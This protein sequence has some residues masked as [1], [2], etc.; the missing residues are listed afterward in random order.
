[1]SVL[2]RALDFR[3]L[4]DESP[5]VIALRSNSL[6]LMLAVFGEYFSAAGARQYVSDLHA[7]IDSDLEALDEY[8]VDHGSRNA[9]ELCRAWINM[10]VLARRQDP[11]TGYEYYELTAIGQTV[12]GFISSLLKPRAAATQSRLAMVTDQIAGLE[13]ATNPDQQKR[14]QA[15]LKQREDLDKQIQRV[16]EGYIEVMETDR[17]R[18]SISDLAELAAQVP[19][20]FARVRESFDE[21]SHELRRNLLDSET[22]QEDILTEVFMNLDHISQSDEGKS[23]NAFYSL[24]LDERSQVTFEEAIRGLDERGM[25]SHLPQIERQMLRTYMMTLQNEALPVSNMMRTLSRN[26]RQFVQSRQFQEYRAIN[27][28]LHE[29]Q[30]LGLDA[31]SLI[32]ATEQIPIE[33]PTTSFRS[34]SVG[35]IR[36]SDRSKEVIEGEVKVNELEDVDIADLKRRIRESEIDFAQLI[37]HVNATVANGPAKISQILT[38]FPAEQGLASVVGLILLAMKHAKRFQEHEVV[39]W[40]GQF[41]QVEREGEIPLYVFEGP[42]DE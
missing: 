3:A 11:K 25:L 41:D 1:M 23:F 28:K 17:A 31:S 2:K 38:E 8:N 16:K 4:Q 42:I 12:L 13:Q 30:K 5:A 22:P 21:I 7:Q 35:R 26:L 20:D 37:K 19:K 32:S 39:Y 34:K 18:E 27:Q 14:L 29:I 15:L 33:V 36:L 9:N 40:H 6:F 10:K 24:L